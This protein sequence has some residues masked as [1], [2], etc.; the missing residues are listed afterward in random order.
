MPE[1]KKSESCTRFAPQKDLK[2]QRQASPYCHISIWHILYQSLACCLWQVGV[3]AEVARIT[4]A[5]AARQHRG[6]RR[7]SL[8]PRMLRKQGTHARRPATRIRWQSCRLHHRATFPGLQF[9][10]AF[11]DNKR[12]AG[13]IVRLHLTPIHPECRRGALPGNYRFRSTDD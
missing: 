3:V 8:V 7:H 11:T 13:S 1:K 4:D 10:H 9:N 12:R 5:S 6:F 2:K